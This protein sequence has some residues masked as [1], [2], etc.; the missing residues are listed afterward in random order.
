MQKKLELY[1]SVIASNVMVPSFATQL[2][3]FL[4]QAQHGSP[5]ETERSAQFRAM[6]FDVS[7]LYL[8]NIVQRHGLE[9]VGA[10]ESASQKDSFFACWARWN[11]SQRHNRKAPEA[12]LKSYGHEL[13]ASAEKL[14][15]RFIGGQDWETLGTEWAEVL[16]AAQLAIKEICLAW[17]ADW[18][19]EKTLVE[20]IERF[21][22]TM[23][24]MALVAITW[25]LAQLQ[26]SH[27]YNED[28]VSGE[29]NQ[30]LRCYSTG[31]GG[32]YRQGKAYGGARTLAHSCF[33][34]DQRRDIDSDRRHHS[35]HR[36]R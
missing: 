12:I 14:K 5:T 1:L 29:T 21:T 22:G 19:D 17:T 8:V 10:G 24:S 36:L 31:G 15:A 20:L 16:V 26:V 27:K 18:I 3:T 7:F 28:H 11:L 23:C 25:V 35:H 4:A 13:L 6:M 33:G 2:E 30:T 32:R 34:V 9:A